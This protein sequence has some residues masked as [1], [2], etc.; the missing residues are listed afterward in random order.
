MNG[1][2]RVPFL[3]S[4]LAAHPVE[5][6]AEK[7]WDR[8]LP[9]DA[10]LFEAV[11]RAGVTFPHRLAPPPVNGATDPVFYGTWQMSPF[12]DEYL[13]GM[14]KA[15]VS[16]YGL[17]TGAR[18]DVLAISYSALDTVGH[19]FGPR[20]HEV[21]DMLVRLDG[22]LADLFDHLDA[23]VGAGRW[24]VALS[25]DHGVSPIPAHVQSMGLRGGV[26]SRDVVTAAVNDLIGADAVVKIVGALAAL[27]PE[28]RDTLLARVARIDGVARAFSAA[29]LLAGRYNAADP[30]AQAVR[31][32]TYEE[33]S[34]DIITV[35]DPY[36]FP[37]TDLAATH[38]TPYRYDQHVP[39]IFLGAGIAPGTY[40][41]TASPADLAPTLARLLGVTLP[42]PHGRALTAALAR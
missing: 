16:S 5:A 20:S 35:T 14:A 29:D 11:G 36:W 17:G 13:T 28:A 22:T 8:S 4:Y 24:V 30:L 27:S 38:G 6:D 7:V 41:V 34:G 3:A 1:P 26:V 32:S 31:L 12:I 15:A 19:A 2:E 10:Y 23:A 39:L 9:A 33:R 42:A 25:S 40:D 37:S 18:H 21:Q